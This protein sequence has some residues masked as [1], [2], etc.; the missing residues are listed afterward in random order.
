MNNTAVSATDHA[1]RIWGEWLPPIFG[2][3]EYTRMLDATGEI[4]RLAT[5]LE[6]GLAMRFPT[7]LRSA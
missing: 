3:I 1:L 5:V 4:G 6:F 2:P 7:A